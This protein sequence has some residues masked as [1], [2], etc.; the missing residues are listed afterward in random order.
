MNDSKYGRLYPERAVKPLRALAF[1]LIDDGRLSHTTHDDLRAA[2]IDLDGLGF[3]AG[4]PLFLLR[5][6]DVLA[7]WAVRHYAGDIA[8]SEAFGGKLSPSQVDTIHHLEELADQMEGWQP[9]KLPD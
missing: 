5:G 8:T 3:P 4:E 6:Q 9:R 1:S 2:V 7:P